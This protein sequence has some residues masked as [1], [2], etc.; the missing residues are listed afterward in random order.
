MLA[1]EAQLFEMNLA[2]VHKM[3]EVNEGE[4]EHYRE[5]KKEYLQT[6]EKE[7]SRV[8]FLKVDLLIE[9][10]NVKFKEE[11]DQ[12]ANLINKYPTRSEL[13]R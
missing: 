3:A 6:I 4:A 1:Y 2:K 10:E 11:Y 9:K 12:I 13:F 7:K 8:Q 5:K